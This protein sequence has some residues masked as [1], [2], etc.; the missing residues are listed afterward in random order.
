MLVTCPHCNTDLAVT[1]ELLGQTVQ[2]PACQGRLKVPA[3]ETKS[4]TS[5]RSRTQRSGWLER[6]HANVDFIKSF[7]FGTL[8]TACFLALL[9][10]F[11]K[12]PIGAL[13]LSRGWVNY[14]ESFLF[15]W[16]MTILAMKWRQNQRQIRATMLELFPQ[17]IG[18]EINCN[19]VGSFID[20]IYKI[21]PSMRDSLIVNRI[22]KALELFE[23]RTD[24]SEVAT[25][26]ST[27]SDIDANRSSGSYAL[28]KVFLWAIP[29]LGFIGTVQGLSV[30]VA[31]LAMGDTTNPEALKASINALTGG[32]SVAFDTTLLGLI[33]S[34]FMSFPMAAV[35][36]KEDETLTLIDAFCTDKLLP[37][38]N[39]THNPAS[40]ALLE[41]A[42]SI[43]GLVSSLALAHE[44]FLINLNS[45]TKL[46]SEAGETLNKRLASHQ[47]TVESSFKD[48]I[49]KLTET[50]TASLT[51]TQEEMN[52]NLTKIATGFDI[53]NSTLRELGQNKI[54]DEAKKKRGF[55]SR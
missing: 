40:S 50:G 55:F 45:A 4:E 44:T 2:C 49:A 41:N 17:R 33:L 52:K 29:I 8:I 22:R 42:E 34:M 38:L 28:L 21:P 11:I 1:P 31:S 5:T 32:L 30:A 24:N 53:I 35:Q 25:F 16:G 20:N 12:S 14:A 48:A 10:P 37:K 54:P 46:L 19:N 6:D 51:K 47:D 13:F 26:L 7:I 3:N 18:N 23:N 43:P 15:F 39:D 27:Q 9:F 36:K